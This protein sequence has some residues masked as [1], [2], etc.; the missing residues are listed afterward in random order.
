MLPLE[1][2]I[3]IY[4]VEEGKNKHQIDY[5]IEN[6]FDVGLTLQQFHD[7]IMKVKGIE[8]IG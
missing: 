7:F 4:G 6:H 5:V 2:Y 1:T 3:K 8:R